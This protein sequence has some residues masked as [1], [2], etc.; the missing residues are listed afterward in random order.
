[1]ASIENS[2]NNALRIVNFFKD[3]VAVS[4]ENVTEDGGVTKHPFFM[5]DC[6]EDFDYSVF[7]LNSKYNEF[8]HKYPF[9]I[10]LVSVYNCVGNEKEMSINN[11]TFFTLDEVIERST[12]YDNI[13]DIGLAY[14]GMGH[15]RVLSMSKTNGKFFF[16]ADG[17]ANGYEREAHYNKYLHFI[18]SDDILYSLEDTL[19]KLKSNNIFENYNA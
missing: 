3:N 9:H 5:S 12:I 10:G 8:L 2:R 14:M 1:M 4:K 19:E 13:L 18:P 6:K 15:V 16:R 7:T 17:G 11:F